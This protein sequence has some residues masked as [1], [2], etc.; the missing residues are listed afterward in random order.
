MT[1]LRIRKNK[2]TPYKTN[3]E[4]GKEIE[5]LRNV[6]TDLERDLIIIETKL[7][8]T[9]PSK[10]KP[11]TITVEE[12]TNGWLLT[13]DDDSGSYK[14]CYR[15]CENMSEVAAFAEMLEFIEGSF[16]PLSSKENN[17]SIDIRV[18]RPENDCGAY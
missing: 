9:K 1:N 12:I 16:G 6:I 14:G 15:G 7:N 17:E 13:V 10:S 18:L 4:T 8:K 5:E 2:V 3:F 11:T